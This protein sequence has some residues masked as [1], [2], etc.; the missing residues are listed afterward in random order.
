MLVI[1]DIPVIVAAP[2]TVYQ[3]CPR[4]VLWSDG[5]LEGGEVRECS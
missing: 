1:S 2:E 4:A 5:A 3:V